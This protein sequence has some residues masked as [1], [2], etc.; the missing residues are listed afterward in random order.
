MIGRILAAVVVLAAAAALAVVAWPQAF[1]LER[2]IGV[3][4]AVAFRGASAVAA[5]IVAVLFTALALAWRWSRPVT[6]WVAVLLIAFA[7]VQVWVLSTRGWADPSMPDAR[8]D[9][10]T[11]LSWNTAGGEPGSDAVADLALEVGADVVVLP[12][13]TYD[14][15]ATTVARMA[16]SGSTMQQFTFAYDQIYDASSTTILISERLGEYTA[17]TS[18][19]TTSELPSLVAIPVDGTGPR[20]VGAHAFTPLSDDL[21]RWSTDLAWLAEQCRIPDTIVAGDF[22]STID[23]WAGLADPGVANARLGSCWDAADRTGNGA[24]GTWPTLL[25]TLLGAPID[26]ILGSPEWEPLGA[27]VI[28]S[29]DG[30][31]SDH[32][33]VVARLV[34]AS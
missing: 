31:G 18:R 16:A 5:V 9:S 20:I 33:P 17:D 2:T 11:V 26:H 4:W 23:H 7:G 14:A 29:V 32:R 19:P 15:A 28:G 24:Q 8:P 3:A 22:N 10:I 13:T 25:P 30:A 34:P 12:E 6:A 21:G 1:G 27:R